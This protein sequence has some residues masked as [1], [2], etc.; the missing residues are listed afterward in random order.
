MK[1][2]ELIGELE[3]DGEID[4]GNE[5]QISQLFDG[6]FRRIV[7]V[8]L[9]NNA[10]L[11]RHHA[12]VPITVYCIS[13][14]GRFSAGPDLHEMQELRAGTLITLEAGIE[15]EVVADPELHILVSKF[16]DS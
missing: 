2:I 3:P 6:P 9:R 14:T 11:S 15:H 8:R 12:D 7:G 10:V 5:K 16:K 13:G 1:H 4:Q